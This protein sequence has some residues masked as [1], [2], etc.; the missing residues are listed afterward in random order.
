MSGPCGTGWSDPCNWNDWLARSQT[1]P[2]R[3]VDDSVL[4]NI[5]ATAGARSTDWTLQFCVAAMVA[6]RMIYM[7]STPGD[8][9]SGN[10]SLPGQTLA[11]LQGAKA[12]AG[13]AQ[14]DP[15]P[16]S[17]GILTG[18]SSIVGIFGAHHAAAVKTE[19]DTNCAV[20]TGYN[21][22]ASSIEQAVMQGV[23]PPDQGSA[24]ITQVV[25][26]LDPVL[27][28]I[29]KN[30]NVSCG[31][32]LA[33]KSLAIFNQQIAMAMLAPKTNFPGL[34]ALLAPPSVASPGAPGTY[35]GASGPTSNPLTGGN[36]G[37]GLTSGV[38]PDT[39]TPGEI[40]L[41]GGVAYVASS[42]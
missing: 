3:L 30:C 15:E 5:A 7:R 36:G 37:V 34:T 25:A 31:A 26:Q 21:Q 16:I 2:Q 6:R 32:R 11:E 27:A 18:I 23:L 41:I 1:A 8:C 33:L 28:R 39:I 9:G 17:K 14:L 4:V 22:A 38:L 20:A 12:V 35:Q 42:L 19:E 40:I 29:A 10:I 13:A 24:L